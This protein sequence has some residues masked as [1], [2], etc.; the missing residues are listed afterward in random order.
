MIQFQSVYKNFG[1]NEVLRGVNVVLEEKKIY[2]IL[3]PNGSGKTS[4]IKAVL[5]LV[6]PDK[7]Q[8]HFQ[9]ESIRGQHTYR[10]H[11][12]Y[13]PQIAQF[14]SNLTTLELIS[15]IKKLRPSQTREDELVQRLGLH[16]HLKKKLANL[17]GG[18]RQKVNILLCFMYDSPILILDEP[19]TGL[20]PQTL[21][22]LKTIIS[23]E[24][25]KNK[26]ILITSHIMQFVEEIADSI[27]YILEGKIY[28][29]GS[30][31]QLLKTTSQPNLE[32][33][34]A[35]LTSESHSND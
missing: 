29:K 19:T 20:D 1:S 31:D 16:E 5:D 11:I 14:P 27:V 23:E 4:L 12:Q 9:G 6:I 34:I 25:A 24:K 7:G 10:Q 26:I 18:T 30:L 28:F 2:A 17:S 21:I 3:G 32:H 15:L 22:T 13:M 33:A 8:I 35:S